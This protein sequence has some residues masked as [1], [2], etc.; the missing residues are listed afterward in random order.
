METRNWKQ[1]VVLLVAAVW[2]SVAVY[3]AFNSYGAPDNANI[4]KGLF[5]YVLLKMVALSLPAV[6]FGSILFWWFGKR[7]L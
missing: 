7:K 4:T 1:F 3:T 5:G 6:L 2:V